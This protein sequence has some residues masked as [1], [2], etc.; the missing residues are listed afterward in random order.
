MMCLQA[1]TQRMKKHRLRGTK[2]INF[3]QGN[4]GTGGLQVFVMSMPCHIVSLSTCSLAAC[5]SDGANESS[6]ERYEGLEHSAAAWSP[7]G[8]G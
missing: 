6:G 1:S 4:L 5:H 2:Q 3:L 8:L 7:A